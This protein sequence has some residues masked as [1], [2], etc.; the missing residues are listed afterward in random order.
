MEFRSTRR[1]KLNRETVRTLT[2]GEMANVAGGAAVAS[3]P[4]TETCHTYVGC[5]KKT[6]TCQETS[7]WACP[8]PTQ[9]ACLKA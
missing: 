3:F 8:K 6:F 5:P 7:V 9:F 1:L 4:R 2:S